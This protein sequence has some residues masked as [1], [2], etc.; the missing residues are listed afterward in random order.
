MCGAMIGSMF[1]GMIQDLPSYDD[2]QNYNPPTISRVYTSEGKLMDEYAQERRIFASS[3]E[4]SQMLKNAFVSAEDKNFY[5]HEGYDPMAILGAIRDAALSKGEDVRGAS[6]ITQQVVKN[7]LLTNERSI[8]RKVQEIVLAHR[9]EEALSKNDILELYMNE[10]FLGV[11]S[12][13]VASA[14]LTYFNKGL[15]ELEI[16]EIAYL[17]GLPQSPSRLHPVKDKARAINRRNYVLKEMMQNGHISGEQYLSAKNEDLKTVQ[18]GDIESHRSVLPPRDYVSD[19]IRRQVS[20]ALG[21]D[22]LFRGGLRIQSTVHPELQKAAREALR[23]GLLRLD[24]RAGVWHKTGKT[25]LPKES[26]ELS[27]WA[28]ELKKLSLVR[29]HAAWSPASVVKIED[30]GAF[31]AVEAGASVAIGFVPRSEARRFPQYIASGEDRPRRTRFLSDLLKVGDVIYVSPGEG[32]A[33]DRPVW[34]LQQLPKVEG[35]LMAIDVRTGQV[36]AMQGGFGFGRS[37]FNRATQAMRQTGSSFKPFLYAAALEKGFNAASLFDDEVKTIRVGN[38]VWTPKNASGRTYGRTTMRVGLERSLNLLTLDIGQFIGLESIAEMV[39]RL[40]VY[41]KMRLFPANM[42]GSQETTLYNMVR[43]YAV[44]ASG[45]QRVDVSLVSRIEDASGHLIYEHSPSKTV[46]VNDGLA[47]NRVSDENGERTDAVSQAIEEALVEVEKD[48]FVLN[49]PRLISEV[50]AF[51]VTDMLKGVVENGTARR[52]QLPF[53]VAGKTGTTNQARDVWFIGYTPNIVVG[54]YIGFDDPKPLGSGSGG[55]SICG[56]VFQEFMETAVKYVPAKDFEPPKTGR[57]AYFS[58]GMEVP[59]RT[60]TREFI[61]LMDGE[62]LP[63]ELDENGVPMRSAGPKPPIANP[64]FG[65]FGGNRIDNLGSG[66]L[67]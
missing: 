3:E 15:E 37:N 38:E 48:D 66:G 11:N 46:M 20:A 2:L 56:P 22:A 47:E 14:A 58:M 42:L 54:C 62:E 44:F 41:D 23:N 27:A 63:E 50:T 61:P 34:R 25:A 32:T 8:E 53:E 30:D 12:Y 21:E 59:Y 19:E 29:D 10:I 1:W 16:H 24:E 13:G 52:V 33:R 26:L 39:E 4:I 31:V 64:G 17:A 5:T 28:D 55:G 49:R 18:S 40:G 36:L 7:F 51:Q 57:Y 67:Y 60:N 45:G 6:T 9:I 65:G 35:A 43:A